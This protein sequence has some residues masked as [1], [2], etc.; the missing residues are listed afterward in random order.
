MSST[1]SEGGLSEQPDPR[2]DNLQLRD[3]CMVQLRG[4]TKEQTQNMLET[5]WGL[6]EI[7]WRESPDFERARLHKIFHKTDRTQI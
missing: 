2:L 4:L 1:A 7:H 6:C 3:R 5:K